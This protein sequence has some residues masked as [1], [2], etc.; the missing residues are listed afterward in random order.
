MCRL[1]K[2]LRAAPNLAMLRDCQRRFLIPA[3]LDD[4][5]PRQLKLAFWL[6]WLAG[7]AAGRGAAS[8]TLSS[9]DGNVVSARLIEISGYEQ[10]RSQK[11]ITLLLKRADR[12]IERFDATYFTPFMPPSREE[13]L[14]WWLPHSLFFEDQIREEGS[15]HPQWTF[16]SAPKRTPRSESVRESH[17]LFPLPHR[18]RS[19]LYSRCR[20][21]SDSPCPCRS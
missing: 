4:C 1:C 10:L 11:A 9:G 16:S 21:K 19:G 7:A 18:V 3:S 12:W 13:L 14:R 5:A 17:P 2:R 6:A 15:C 8:T 20:Y